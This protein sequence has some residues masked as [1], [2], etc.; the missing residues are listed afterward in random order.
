MVSDFWG[1]YQKITQDYI[2]YTQKKTQHT[3]KKHTRATTM[4]PKRRDR[5]KPPNSTDPV[6]SDRS[7][8]VESSKPS[9]PYLHLTHPRVLF[10]SVLFVSS[11]ALLLII[12]LSSTSSPVP[13]ATV[14]SVY[15]RGLVRPDIS[16]RDILAVSFLYLQ[17]VRMWTCGI[18]IITL[19]FFACWCF[20]FVL[21]LVHVGTW[22]SF[23]ESVASALSESCT[24]ICNPL[25]IS[26]FF[27]FL[28]SF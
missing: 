27:F 3:E 16:Y 5:R 12:Y 24:G 25:V 4:P 10:L 1:S 19:F 13:P 9:K 22:K 23:W 18:S 7:T 2:T 14:L 20:L 21:L 28:S 6:Q 17:F 26:F 15:D 11:I 8:R